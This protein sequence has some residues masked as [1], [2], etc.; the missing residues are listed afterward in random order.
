MSVLI[1]LIILI[2]IV[3]GY[4]VF[5]YN[6]NNDS[7]FDNFQQQLKEQSPNDRYLSNIELYS[8][9]NHNQVSRNR[10]N[11]HINDYSYDGLT[12]EQLKQRVID[13]VYQ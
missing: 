13:N 10:F 2:I 9:D 4:F 11:K 1:V 6:T 12:E 7:V 8:S 5:F 3:I